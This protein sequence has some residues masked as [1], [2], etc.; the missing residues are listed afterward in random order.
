MS[1][2]VCS[3]AR[4]S[5]QHRG[6]SLGLRLHSTFASLANTASIRSVAESPVKP[7]PCAI[8]S[9][10]GEISG[11]ARIHHPRLADEA[12]PVCRFASP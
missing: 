2:W 6:A 5:H 7:N 12:G 4:I 1:P 10:V 11:L 8:R 3:L 9:R